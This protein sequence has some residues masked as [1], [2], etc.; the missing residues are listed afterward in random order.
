MQNMQN[1]QN[2]KNM[3]IVRNK[4]NMQNMQKMQK[5]AKYAKFA[6]YAKQ[7]QYANYAENADCLKQSMPVSVVPLAIFFLVI[8]MQTHT[9][10]N[11]FACLRIKAVCTITQYWSY[12]A[13]GPGG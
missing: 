3:Q 6:K 4:Q 9:S 5:N 12:H 1:T 2:M 7:A 10:I 8:Q 13:L 11:L